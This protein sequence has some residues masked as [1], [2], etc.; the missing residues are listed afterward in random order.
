MR[1]RV[2]DVDWIYRR[3]LPDIGATAGGAAQRAWQGFRESLWHGFKALVGRMRYE[4]SDEGHRG[5]FAPTGLM[6]MA[7]AILLILYL[8]AYYR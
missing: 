4:L 2:W 3:A 1:G 5:H 7:A 6:A 8:L